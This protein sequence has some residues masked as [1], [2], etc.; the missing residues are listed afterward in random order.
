MPNI[1]FLSDNDVFK[2]D[3]L[4]Q[5][6]YHIPEFKIPNNEDDII[7]IIIIDEKLDLLE[8]C[9]QKEIKAPVIFLSKT[10]KT[11]NNNIH[12]TI[13]KPLVLSSFIDDIKSS[14]NIFENSN[15]GLLEFNKYKLYPSRKEILNL[16]N[17]ETIKLTEKEVAIIKYL[18]KNQGKIVSKNDLMQ[19]VWGYVADV[20]THTVETHIYRLRQKVEQDDVSAQLIQTSDGGYKL[21]L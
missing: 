20:A 1:L 18:Y 4:D 15:D 8:K 5:I 19:E 14:I 11:C 13:I 9:F 3:I 17:N 10:D 12:H 2:K 21:K 6:S 7:D 16:R